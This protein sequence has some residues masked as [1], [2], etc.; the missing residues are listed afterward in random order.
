M[1][2]TEWALY[3]AP[4]A[5]H[6]TSH[7]FPK[8]LFLWVNLFGEAVRPSMW[9]WGMPFS[10]SI[11]CINGWHLQ[12]NFVCPCLMRNSLILKSRGKGEKERD[13]VYPG[14][15]LCFQGGALHSRAA[16]RWDPIVASLSLLLTDG[17]GR[18]V[19]QGNGAALGTVFEGD[20]SLWELSCVAQICRTLNILL[21]CSP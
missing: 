9:N 1:G 2:P 12:D 19:L 15:G 4:S 17:R 21:L 10:P 3:V 7:S 6:A 8:E 18:S 20:E 11:F 5:S 13:S 14:K 16:G